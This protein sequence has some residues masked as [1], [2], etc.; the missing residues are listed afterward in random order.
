MNFL[1]KLFTKSDQKNQKAIPPIA[2][3][4]FAPL[5]MKPT[6]VEDDYIRLG[7]AYPASAEEK[8]LVSVITSAIMAGDNPDTN[9]K[10]KNVYAIDED[11]EVAAVMACAIAADDQPS[12]S[13]KLK[14]I[15]QL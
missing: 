3:A 12:S 9:V 14:S 10:V 13:F 2:S 1:K 7:I 11:K 15:T 4:P 8:E 6:E 5:K